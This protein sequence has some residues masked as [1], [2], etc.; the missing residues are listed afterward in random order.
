MLNNESLGEITG[1]NFQILY[2]HTC[3]CVRARV[4]LCVHDPEIP[5]KLV[6]VGIKYAALDYIQFDCL[7]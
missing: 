5:V 3:V 2:V 7:E 4:H 6:S 1:G